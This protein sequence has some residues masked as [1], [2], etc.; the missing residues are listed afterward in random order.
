MDPVT[1]F[2]IAFVVVALLSLI[3][4]LIAR[5]ASAKA[6]TVALVVV[7]LLIF[8]MFVFMSLSQKE[9]YVETDDIDYTTHHPNT[10]LRGRLASPNRQHP[11]ANWHDS[12]NVEDAPKDNCWYCI[13]KPRHPVH[14]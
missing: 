1:Q 5:H 11:L 8:V 6:A 2:A 14:F 12:Y 9:S 4:T 10:K 7:I 3:N 13:D